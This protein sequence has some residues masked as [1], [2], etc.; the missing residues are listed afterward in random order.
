MLSALMVRDGQAARMGSTSLYGA[1]RIM[2]QCLVA[3]LLAICV[4]APLVD[5]FDHWDRT[6]Q[7]G[8][9]TEAN[10]VVIA[11]C[12]GVGFLFVRSLL[13]RI[14]ARRALHLVVSGVLFTERLASLLVVPLPDSSPPTPLRI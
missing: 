10:L 14:Q 12:A 13:R 8:N 6:L 5:S 7:D 3:I 9:D 4:S 1:R 2:G 11:V